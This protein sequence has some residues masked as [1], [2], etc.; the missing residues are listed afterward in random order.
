MYI[1]F[2]MGSPVVCTCV[3]VCVCTYLALHGNLDVMQ[4]LH[5][6]CAYDADSADSCGVCPV[7][8]AA[9]G[10]HV[11][12]VKFLVETWHI[13]LSKEDILGRH[14]LHHASQSGAG[15]VIDYL[16]SAGADV[17][18]TASVNA[19]SPLHYAAKV[20]QKCVNLVPVCVCVGVGVWL[21]PGSG[22]E[23]IPTQATFHLIFLPLPPTS[24]TRPPTS[25]THQ[26][27]QL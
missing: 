9:R 13:D 21:C 6:C 17:N 20:S 22:P 26:S 23:V 24:P 27:T 11:G 1:V 19:I 16:V 25:P 10:N 5:E 18:L 3:C 7:M 2:G 15:E 14:G 8:D 4:L 12:V